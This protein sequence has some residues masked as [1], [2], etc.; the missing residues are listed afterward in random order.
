MD[1]KE[2]GNGQAA[3]TT[4][5]RS[6]AQQQGRD[7]GGARDQTG[8]AAGLIDTRVGS[9]LVGAALLDDIIGLVISS[10]VSNLGSDSGS[11]GTSVGDGRSTNPSTSIAPW[12]A[13]R[14][15]VSSFLLLSITALLSRFVLA[16]FARK[17]SKHVPRLLIRL[18]VSNCAAEF[19]T[20]AFVSVI[21]IFA[22]IAH[23]VGSSILIG[24]F[25][26]GAMMS[27]T[28]HALE[29]SYHSTTSNVPTS[30]SIDA[31]VGQHL[32]LLTALS[33]HTTIGLISPVQ[34]YILAPFFFAS[35]G[36]AIPVR[37]LFEGQTVWRGILFAGL[38]G[39]AK[40]VAGAWLLAADAVERR[41]DGQKTNAHLQLRQL[42]HAG[43]RAAAVGAGQ[44]STSLP[45]PGGGGARPRS[46][47]IASRRSLPA[48]LGAP[49]PNTT[50]PSSPCTAITVST[51]NTSASPPWP[52]ALFLGLTLVARGEIGFLI[53]NV[54]L[55][56]GLLSVQSFNVGVWAVVLNTLVGPFGVGW[57]LKSSV[58]AQIAKGRW[59]A[60]ERR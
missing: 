60:Q 53:L 24:C 34:R 43:T 26:A 51:A 52:P 5:T 9:I 56:R 13:A 46:G 8:E 18:K 50:V 4:T 23:Y 45:G 57:L 16:P 20:L 33:P 36:A 58:G 37:S 3:A 14:P 1:V 12:T 28:Y 10:V 6:E 27:H 7:G 30:T 48:I 35:V 47:S 32:S 25:C 29:R 22:T 41:V 55:Q 40:L 38:M 39:A 59:G 31:D 15:I 17:W 19:G 49:V 11:S 2:Q 21:A 54:A 44:S 42:P